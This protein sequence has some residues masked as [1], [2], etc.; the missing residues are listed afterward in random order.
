MRLFDAHSDTVYRLWEDRSLSF[1]DSKELHVTWDGLIK[2]NGTVQCFA[3]Y[4]PENIRKESA[5]DVALEM[6]DLFYRDILYR[7]PKM[8]P[9]TTKRQIAQLKKG[10]VGAILTLEGCDVI[11][12]SLERLRTLYRLGVSSIG[13]TWNYANSLADGI[14]EKRGAGLTS[15][16]QKVVLE[17]NH[18]RIWTD[19]SHLSEKSFW[20]VLEIGEYIIASHS[21]SKALCPNPRNLTNEQI[22]A[23][24]QKNAA[25]GI[26]FVPQFLTTHPHSSIQDVL[27]HVEYVCNLGGVGNIG[28]GSD[29]D[30][31]TQTVTGLSRYE[32]YTN[33]INTLLNYYSH[34]EVE[35]FLFQNFYQRFPK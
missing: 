35:G 30:G 21:N 25:I 5:F 6:I 2:A 34:S 33:L 17:N 15:F 26:T 10:E 11:G 18:H 1:K 29:F 3:I 14:L 16:G 7:F 19:V 31:I 9:V 32:D 20:D 22:L 24:I 28:F 27:R 12:T 23:L 8:K 13:L 4:I